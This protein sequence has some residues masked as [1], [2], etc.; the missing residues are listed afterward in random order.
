MLNVITARGIKMVSAAEFYD[1]IHQDNVSKSVKSNY[2]FW[3]QRYITHRID[4]MVTET[5]DFVPVN[6]IPLHKKQ[7]GR[8][9][10][11][12]DY[13]LTFEFLRQLCMDIKTPRCKQ[14]KDW[15]SHI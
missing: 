14:I 5:V 6:L 12:K 9:Y 7:Y 15:T 11:R 10:K 1:F 3:C 2:S 4:Q 13:L 8:G